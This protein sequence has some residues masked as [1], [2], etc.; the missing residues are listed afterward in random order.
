MNS[1]RTFGGRW[2]LI[3][4]LLALIALFAASPTHAAQIRGANDIVVGRDEVIADDLYVA[5][6]SVTIDGTIEGDLIAVA[7]QVTINGIVEGDVL[8]AGQGVVINGTVGDDVRAAGQAI[9][10]GPSAR[11]I[12]D[13]AVVGLSLEN[14]SG[15]VVK[16]DVLIG[17]YQALLS[18]DIGRDVRGGLDR[19]E[20]RG[21]IGGDVDV[22]VS[23]D[24]NPAAIQFSPAGQTPIPRVQPNLTMA[25]SARIGGKLIYRS[26]AA[27]DVNSSAQVGGGVTFD[28]LPAN[29]TQPVVPWLSALQRLAAL[30]LVGLLLVW[31]F[32]TWMRRLADTV[33]ARPLPS[34]GWGLVAFF[35]FIA[36][37]LGVIAVTIALAIM[38]GYLTLGG[39]VAMIISAGVLLSAV[40]VIG[41]IA[42]TAYV[43]EIIVGYMAGR[44]LL[45]RTQPSWAE[46]SVVPL[47]VGVTLYVVVRALPWLGGFVAIAVVLFGLGVLWQW[48][49]A[50]FQRTHPTPAPVSGLQPA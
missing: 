6:N 19:L 26:S 20:L 43:A 27:A 32:P 31:R 35:A 17:A 37:V 2:G 48:A 3:L 1:L 40:M 9:L 22:S 24:Q 4:A 28:Q 21:T 45:R 29:V 13:L 30:L 39:L 18:G 15:S 34:L 38:F 12:G 11:V 23:G 7:S 49:R 46:R 25:D 44:W 50:S 5:G 33:E 16:S 10:L 8:A 42:F 14:Q 36:A 41:Y 47:V